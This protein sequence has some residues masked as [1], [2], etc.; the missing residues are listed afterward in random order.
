MGHPGISGFSQFC[1]TS[2]SNDF[3]HSFANG[4]AK[5][6]P[7][8][9]IDTRI[10]KVHSTRAASTTEADVTG[11]FVC[12]IKKQRQWSNKSTFQNFYKKEIIDDSET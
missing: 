7:M 8:A 10:F 2:Q 6:L 11:V 4:F 3:I 1:E 5:G 12:D 9:G